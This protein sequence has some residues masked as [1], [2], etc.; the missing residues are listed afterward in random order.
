MPWT[1]SRELKRIEAAIE[2]KNEAELRWAENDCR[3][4]LAHAKKFGPAGRGRMDRVRSLLKS[5]EAA[6]L[7]GKN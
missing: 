4:R 5:I 6:I 3:A 2:H 7:E 1:R